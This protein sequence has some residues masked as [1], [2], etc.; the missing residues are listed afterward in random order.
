MGAVLPNLDNI[1]EE[2]QRE[3]LQLGQAILAI[4]LKPKEKKLPHFLPR[5]ES[6]ESLASEATSSSEYPSH[7]PSAEQIRCRQMNLLALLDIFV[8]LKESNGVERASL[9]SIL[10]S[11]SQTAAAMG[12]GGVGQPPDSRLLN[13]VAIEVENQR[14]LLEELSILPPGPLRNLVLDLITLSPELMQIQNLVLGGVSLDEL[15]DQYGTDSETLWDMLTVYIDKLRG[16]ELVCDVAC[17]NYLSK[18]FLVFPNTTLFMYG[19][20][21]SLWRRSRHVLRLPL[22]SPAAAEALRPAAPSALPTTCRSYLRAR[23]AVGLPKTLAA[24][25]GLPPPKTWS[26]PFNQCHPPK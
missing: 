2:H 22:P 25:P 15:R 26:K 3:Q 21:S 11:N 4:N 10:V 14:R 13:D 20:Y 24:V 9:T 5:L 1:V 6:G 23:S 18:L 17:E 16:L 7:A 19:I 12:G 8:R